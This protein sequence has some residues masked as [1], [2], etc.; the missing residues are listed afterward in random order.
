M[1]RTTDMLFNSMIADILDMCRTTYILNNLRVTNTQH[2]LRMID[3]LDTSRIMDI[4]YLGGSVTS[5]AG[6]D[7]GH[8]EKG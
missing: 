3:M 1:S 7:H 5:C 6:E 2:N 8:M 4:L